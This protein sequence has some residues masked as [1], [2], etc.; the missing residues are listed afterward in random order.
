MM[1]WW[2]NGIL[3]EN[4]EDPDGETE[5]AGSILS[6]LQAFQK[7]WRRQVILSNL[8]WCELNEKALLR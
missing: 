8:F 1:E 2:N 5:R 7:P 6:I 4:E 3:G